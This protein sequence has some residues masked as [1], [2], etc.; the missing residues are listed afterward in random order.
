M[1]KILS[2]ILT[3][4]LLIGVC[5]VFA[6]CAG[7]SSSITVAIPNDT[8]NEARALILL[9]AQGI[10]KLKEGA[11]ITATIRD[12][13]E[14]PKNI[15]FEEIEAAQ[16]PNYLK[17]YDYAII[18]SN[19]AIAAGLNPLND[20]LLIEGAYSNYS[21]IVAVKSGNEKTDK[22]KRRNELFLYLVPCFDI[23]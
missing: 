13:V 14:N 23:C 7:S 9:E 4:V 18:N 3:L 22:T 20:S 10:I 11:G 2:V 6:G 19:Y 17:D 1:K 5:G 8:T 21:N 16:I 15:K 12:I